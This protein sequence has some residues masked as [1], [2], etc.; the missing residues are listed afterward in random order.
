MVSCISDKSKLYE[1]VVQF[2]YNALNSFEL[3]VAAVSIVRSHTPALSLLLILMKPFVKVSNY[4]FFR[5][6]PKWNAPQTWN[7]SSYRY[8]S[9]TPCVLS[10]QSKIFR[11][12][13]KQYLYCQ[14]RENFHLRLLN[15]KL[16]QRYEL[17]PNLQFYLLSFSQICDKKYLWDLLWSQL[18]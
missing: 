11:S 6:P 15:K 9:Y 8:I 3:T 5:D 12:E 10:L 14:L 7:E 17:F 13:Y 4:I 16:I 1:A 2:Y 18:S